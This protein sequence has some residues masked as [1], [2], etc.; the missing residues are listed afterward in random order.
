MIRKHWLGT[1]L[2]LM[3][4]L[5]FAG[6][7]AEVSVRLYA[8]LNPTFGQRLRGLDVLTAKVEPH[9]DFGYRMKPLETIRYKN[10]TEANTNAMGFR[11]PLV[12]VPKP[13][14][15]FRIILLGG[16]TTHGWRV[17]DDETIDAYMRELAA[18]ETSLGAFEVVNLAFDGYDAYQL[19]ERLQSDGLRL[20]PDVVVVNSGINDVRNAHYPDLADPDPRTILYL[21]LLSV[22]RDIARRGHPTLWLWLKH[23][24][25]SARLPAL[26]RASLEERRALAGRRALAERR[27]V[28]PNPEAANNFERNLWRIV[29][30]LKSKKIPIL[31]SSAPSSLPMKYDP[32]DTSTISYWLDNAAATQMYR[33]TLAAKMR[34]VAEKLAADGYPAGYLNVQLAPDRFLDD[35]HLTPE[36]NRE[37][38]REVFAEIEAYLDFERSD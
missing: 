36:G 35:G 18:Q 13:Q 22:Q 1:A 2:L 4:A 3:L 23:F 31:F 21:G 24:S 38:A 16:S 19:Y 20:D 9:G 14:G 30:L 34:S 8:G 10:G 26:I 12:T 28:A 33:D 25:Y 27:T 32:A 15:T 37:M 5:A 11:G 6:A 17:N 29:D 7:L